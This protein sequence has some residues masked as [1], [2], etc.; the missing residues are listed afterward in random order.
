MMGNKKL[1]VWL[2]LIFSLVLIVGMFFGFKMGNN[3]SSK[4][5]LKTTKSNFSTGSFWT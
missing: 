5:F 3:G 2:P 1:Q 4:G